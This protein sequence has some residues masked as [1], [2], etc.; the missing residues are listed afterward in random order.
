V[1]FWIWLIGAVGYAGS[2]LLVS[3]WLGW[4][5]RRRKPLE[6]P[7]LNRLLEA[8]RQ[9]LGLRR[10]LEVIETPRVKSPAVFGLLRPR[11]LLPP[12]LLNTFSATELRHVLLHELAHL[13]RGDLALNWFMG[14]VQAVHWFNPLVWMLFRRIR[15]DRELACAALAL[16]HASE[17]DRA[18]YGRTILKLLEDWAM[19]SRLAGAVGILEERRALE[20]RVRAIAC[21]RPRQPAY[22]LVATLWISLAAV[23]LT[24]GR[25]STLS[26]ASNINPALLYQR[27]VL[28]MGDF[29]EEVRMDHSPITAG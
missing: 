3:S 17:S 13:R 27:A 14:G 24:D 12:G 28:L 18:A 26:T 16:E 1:V 29:S 9:N 8:C 2:L 20:R 23:N 25:E 6:D 15:S 10:Q 21:F 11:L 4:H 7:D 5:L 19:P 22:F